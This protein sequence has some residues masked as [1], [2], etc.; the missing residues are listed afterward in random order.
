MSLITAVSRELRPNGI[1][2][3]GAADVPSSL[4]ETGELRLCGCVS[5]IELEC[6]QQELTALLACDLRAQVGVLAYDRIGVG[7]C[8]DEIAVDAHILLADGEQS[9]EATTAAGVVVGEYC[10]PVDPKRSVDQFDLVR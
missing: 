4:V 2:P 1:L 3:Q 10:I 7:A 8:P 6:A 5:P 9:A